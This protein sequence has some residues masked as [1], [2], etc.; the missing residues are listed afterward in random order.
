MRPIRVVFVGVGGQGNLLAS[1]LLGEAA[2]SAGVPVNLSEIHG[3]AQ[4]G[5]VVESAVLMGDV[6]SYIVSPGYADVLVSFEPVETLRA[7]PKCNNESTVLTN[8]KPLPPYTVAIGK[9]SYPPVDEMI[10]LI[11]S[12]IQKVVAFDGSALALQAGSPLS[13]NMVMLGA[14]F[15]SIDLPIPIDTMKETI[16][17]KT[18]K[19]FLDINLKAFDLGYGEAEKILSG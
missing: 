9:G 10:D 2:L 15:K 4:R 8:T 5:G 3:M 12:K 6:V 17:E 16:K 1:S 14:L 7:L 19:A 18:K 11:K 13:L